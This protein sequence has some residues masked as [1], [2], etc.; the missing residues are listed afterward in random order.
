[1]KYTQI[2]ADTFE[3]LQMN[4]GIITDGFT[5]ESGEIKKLVGATTGGIQFQDSPEYTDLG[6]DID[7]CPKNTMELKRIDSRE[8]TMSGTFVT[9]SPESAQ[10]M[11]GTADVDSKDATHII[12]RDDLLTTDFKDLWFIGDYSNVNTGDSA[13]FLAIHIMNALNTDGFQIQSSDKEKGQFAFNY[14]AHYSMEK[15]DQVPY[16]VY[17][18]AGKATA[19]A[20]ANG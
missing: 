14:T 9:I 4:A 8:I 20:K 18:K 7:N 1:M 3:K 17:V 15:Q 19:A 2:P 12:P 5:P 16:E 11:I 13:G 10:F 6:E